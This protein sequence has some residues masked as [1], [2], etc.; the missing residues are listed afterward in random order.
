M[1]FKVIRDA[2][3]FAR[4]HLDFVAT[5][6]DFDLLCEIGFHQENGAPLTMKELMRLEVTSAA[7]L[8]RRLRRLKAKGVIV[9]ARSPADARVI[10]FSLS[11]RVQKAFARYLELF[12]ASCQAA[13]A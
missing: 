9:Q 7:T 4:R 13:A 5:L 11:P 10:E 8:Q 12:G 3:H 1:I 6:E 2:R